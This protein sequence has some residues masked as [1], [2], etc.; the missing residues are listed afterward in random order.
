MALPPWLIWT[1]TVPGWVATVAVGIL[2]GLYILG[3]RTLPFTGWPL[4]AEMVV[5]A[6]FICR[7]WR[8]VVQCW[9]Y[10]F[11]YKYCQAIELADPDDNIDNIDNRNKLSANDVSVVMPTV[12]PDEPW[13]QE[14]LA[15]VC[16]N[17]PARIFV[18]TVG[19]ALHKVA[20]EAVLAYRNSSPA[21]GAGVDIRVS[22]T[23]VANKRAQ[24]SSAIDDI[25]TD[26]TFFVDSTALWP[27]R[28]LPA[29]LAPFA[30]DP[31][32]GLVGTEKLPKRLA[33]DSYWA[34]S[35]NFLG[36]AYLMRHNYEIAASSAIDGG[37]FI[38]SGRSCGI[39]TSI[40]KDP[41]FRRGYEDER[42]L[43]PGFIRCIA[44]VFGVHLAAEIGP[45]VADDDNYIKRWCEEHDIR[46]KF[47]CNMCL[48]WSRTTFRS[49]P[50]TLLSGR[51]WRNHPWSMYGVQ[52]ATITNFA[53]FFDPLLVYFYVQTSWFQGSSGERGWLGLA[54][55]VAWILLSKTVKLIPL[56]RR[57]PGDII[58]LP[59]YWIFAYYHSWIKLRALLTF[60]DVEW[61]GRDLDKINRLAQKG[62]R[63][64]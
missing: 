48:R 27:A 15:S 1:L 28:H 42:I 29:A 2:P 5:V 38:I 45:L 58:F 26:F 20:E 10:F 34:R 24:I 33:S 16:A 56:F 53:L 44:R 23:A 19:D 7:N 64:E 14:S 9:S 12:D 30:E 40:L 8:S 37:V 3:V 35:W 21:A 50:R 55:L 52:L 57:H 11:W 43:I 54:A 22:H 41:E 63:S 51:E 49:N 4:T 6:V 59:A 47:Q 39:R 61:A 13:F 60:W 31:R 36:A 32:I 17:A 18:V 62:D 25:E 46:T